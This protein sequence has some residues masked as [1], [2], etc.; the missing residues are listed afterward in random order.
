MQEIGNLKAK[1]VKRHFP[2]S[3]LL[4]HQKD[5]S[6]FVGSSSWGRNSAST[7]YY[8]TKHGS[9]IKTQILEDEAKKVLQDIVSNS[10]KFQKS[11]KCH[12]QQKDDSLILLKKDIK[13]IEAKME[14]L[15]TLNDNM[16]KRLDFLLDAGDNEALQAFKEDCQKNYTARKQKIEELERK[17]EQLLI[18]K[19]EIRNLKATQGHY[20]QMSNDALRFVTQKDF[21]AL[22]SVYRNLFKRVIVK[23]L[24]QSKIELEFVLNGPDTSC[25]QNC[26]LPG[27]AGNTLTYPNNI[28]NH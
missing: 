15:S 26:I 19:N 14:E 3:G 9:R 12:S 1:S 24:S 7:Y 18:A 28:V 2:L 22:K 20:L 8:N 17:K 10:S 16:E 4:C 23:Y 11:L 6:S 21:L 13:D 27:L 25:P 5:G